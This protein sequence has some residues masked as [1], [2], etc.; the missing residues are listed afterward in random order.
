GGQREH[1]T[2]EDKEG[3]RTIDLSK[4]CLSRALVA[5]MK[6]YAP[7][8]HPFPRDSRIGEIPTD[9]DTDPRAM[10]FHQ[11][12]NGMWVRAALLAYLFDVDQRIASRFRKDFE[13]FHDYNIGVL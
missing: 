4:Y 8:L 5:R 11:V 2:T 13:E 12:R 3:Y 7:I 1:D 6:D 9:I 10:Y